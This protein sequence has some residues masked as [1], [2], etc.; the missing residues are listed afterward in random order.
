LNELILIAEEWI[1][2]FSNHLSV[3]PDEHP[4]FFAGYKL[5]KNPNLSNPLRI[6][7]TSGPINHT[8][9]LLFLECNEFVPM[10]LIF[11]LS[12]WFMRHEPRR[13]IRLFVR[14]LQ[15]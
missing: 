10:L 6:K 4:S 5:V 11:A 1:K 12:R 2:D 13:G 3:F 14:S 8:T 7:P 9:L 15:P